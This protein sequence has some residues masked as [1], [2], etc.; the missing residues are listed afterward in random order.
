M[1]LLQE[2]PKKRYRTGRTSIA[3][4]GTRHAGAPRPSG[5]VQPPTPRSLRETLQRAGTLAWEGEAVAPLFRGSL[6]F[7]SVGNCSLVFLD[8]EYVGEISVDEAARRRHRPHGLL[9]VYDP[10]HTGRP[11]H[12]ISDPR[13]FAPGFPRDKGRFPSRDTAALA[14]IEGLLNGGSLRRL[15]S[16]WGRDREDLKLLNITTA[17][18]VTPW[19]RVW[20]G[21]GELGWLMANRKRSRAEGRWY[22]V[23]PPALGRRRKRGHFQSRTETALMLVAAIRQRYERAPERFEDGSDL[24]VPGSGDWNR[25]AVEL[26]RQAEQC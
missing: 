16:C 5:A 15:E 2:S 26:L 9:R 12:Y 11:F 20:Y 8:G 17:S 24:G 6:E 10:F 25:T 21:R 14:L 22:Y 4:P 13:K 19:S 23:G 18:L 7:A 3:A 1:P